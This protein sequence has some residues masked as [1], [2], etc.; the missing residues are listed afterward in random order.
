M[1][2]GKIEPNYEHHQNQ[3]LMDTMKY[4]NVS[5]STSMAVN[6]NSPADE[7]DSLFISSCWSSNSGMQAEFMDNFGSDKLLLESTFHD[8]A[9]SNM[10]TLNNLLDGA[11]NDLAEL[12][13]LPPFTGYTANLSINGIQGH[14]Y[15][16]ISQRNLDKTNGYS[17]F[18]EQNM[19][20]SSTCNMNPDSVSEQEDETFFSTNDSYRDCVDPDSVSSLN[21]ET[22]SQSTGETAANIKSEVV[23]YDIS[24]IDDIA[25]IIGSAIADTTV[26]NPDSEDPTGSRDS[27]MDLDAW[28]DST[29]AIQQKGGL[30]MS[31]DGLTEY[32]VPPVQSS[33]MQSQDIDALSAS[34]YMPLL[35]NR[36]QNGP[37]IKQEMLHA[38]YGNDAISTSS[39]PSNV[40]STT[41]NI[42][43]TVNGRFLPQYINNLE[44]RIPS[45]DLINSTPTTTKKSRNK[46]QKK[47]IHANLYQTDQTLGV[48]GKEKPVHR[49]NICNRGFLN[50]SN[51]KVHVRLHT[52][53]KPFRTL[54][55]QPPSLP[56]AVPLT[57]PRHPH[58]L[59]MDTMKYPNL[60]QSASMAVNNGAHV[61]DVDPLFISSCWNSNAAIQ[62]DFIDAH[63]LMLDGPVGH[64]GADKL[65]LDSPLHDDAELETKATM[66]AL[67]NLLLNTHN[68]LAELKPLPP[69]TGYTAN[70]SI[71]GIQGHHYHTISQR[72][73]EENNNNNNTYGGYNEQNIVSSS[74]CN[75]P[76]SASSLKYED[77]SQ[78][79]VDSA[80]NVKTEVSDYDISSIEDIAAII[81]SAIADTTVPGNNH[82]D[83]EGPA[84][85][86]DSWMDLDALID[87]ACVDQ[88]KSLMA[89]FAMPAVQS[90]QQ[91]H[92]G[93][94]LQTLLTHGYMPLLQNR[95]QNGAAVK[96][97]APSSTSYADAM[98]PPSNV[99]STTENLLVTANGRFLPQYAHGLG[100]DRRMRSPDVLQNYPHTTT[101]ASKKPR[102]RAQKKQQ[103]QAAA[104]AFQPDQTLG[105]LGKEKPVH[106]CNVCN[107]G[108]LNKSNIKV[109][110]RTHTGEKPFRCDTCAKAFRQKAHLLKHQQ[111]HKRIGRD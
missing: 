63:K 26:P 97:E 25:A 109:H 57:T 3:S 82:P 92:G 81:G 71:N 35:K 36:L 68:S 38:N 65:L 10:D 93:S 101:N 58:P 19:V 1:Q 78:S 47:Q 87:G 44:N 52:G 29:C 22:C 74:T 34:G 85:S 77:C 59:F 72:H 32:I 6:N 91:H 100:E 28:I 43:V 75:A 55:Q 54:P 39:P 108:F 42:F 48:M 23:E 51:I 94:A 105:M 46:A 5:Q 8:D 76:D 67:D 30:I 111:I 69:F 96:Q 13:P 66:D 103:Q 49:C 16:T 73:S 50:K 104:G 56:N 11:D 17:N 20:T 45:P 61:D 95:L 41:D 14:H 106:R 64:I 33:S 15:H 80:A 53:E 99:V 90:Q 37:P 98:S 9:K 102:S 60:S 31:P 12:K 89:E 21:Y 86:R 84:G 88:Q 70:L 110:L 40:V 83:G 18:N 107:R 62:S 4:L 24:S 2:L 7:V 27:W 79:G